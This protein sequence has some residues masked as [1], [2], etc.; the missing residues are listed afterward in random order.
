MTLWIIWKFMSQKSST[1]VQTTQHILSMFCEHEL[2]ENYVPFSM[3]YVMMQCF[4]V[5]ALN[6]ILQS[7]Q[8]QPYHTQGYF[9]YDIVHDIMLKIPTQHVSYLN[10]FWPQHITLLQTFLHFDILHGVKF[11]FHVTHPNFS[12]F[13]SS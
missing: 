6:K 11:S 7:L 4:H 8:D 2:K 9:V 13:S 12:N 3:F 1:I 10:T 5:L